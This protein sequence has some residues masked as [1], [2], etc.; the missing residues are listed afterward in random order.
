MAAYIPAA[1]PA[2]TRSF[3]M[4]RGVDIVYALCGGDGGSGGGYAGPACE[5]ERAVDERRAEAP[6]RRQEPECCA[7]D[8]AEE[9]LIASSKAGVALGALG[10]RVE[11]L[12]ARGCEGLPFSL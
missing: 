4:C 8:V 6:L 9:D 1:A 10:Y 2:A 3:T 12:E 7:E 5:R 11:I